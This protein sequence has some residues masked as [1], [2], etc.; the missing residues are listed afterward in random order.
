M[1][2]SSEQTFAQ[3]YTK[4]RQLVEYL[5]MQPTYA[6]SNVELEPGDLTDLLDSI[7][8]ANDTVASKLSV[9]QT[10]QDQ[11][12]NLVK[13]DDGIIKRA[14]QIR[15]HI[16]SF[17]PKGKKEKD[18]EKAKKIVQKL[19][20]RRLTKKPPL[21]PDGTQPK[22]NSTIEVSFGSMHGTGKELLE[23]I[24]TIPGYSPSNPN[25][26]IVN[27]TAY[28][29][30]IGEKN[31]SVAKLNEEYDDAAEARLALYNTLAGRLTK[32]KLALASQYGKDSNVYK[33]AVAYM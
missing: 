8:D 17:L 30:S 28:L 12:F 5:I 21:N 20:G 15:D 24:K 27:F 16:G 19:R 33:D 25:L 2:S 13:G 18:Y 26:T 22:T 10:E 14:T 7:E 31:K 6:P 3:R 4:A 23:I 29:A 32:I 9:V 11:R 1:A